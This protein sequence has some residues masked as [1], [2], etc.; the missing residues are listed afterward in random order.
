MSAFGVASPLPLLLALLAGFAL[1]AWLRR[2]SGP[3]AERITELY[4]HRLQENSQ[5]IAERDARLAVV[6]QEVQALRAEQQQ[7]R[8]SLADTEVLVTQLRHSLAQT[9]AL[10]RQL[11]EREQQLAQAHDDMDAMR[12]DYAAE[13]AELRRRLGDADALRT[14]LARYEQQ[15]RTLDARLALV[16]RDKDQAIAEFATRIAELEPLAQRAAEANAKAH[17]EAHAAATAPASTA[18]DAPAAADAAATPGSLRELER[19]LARLRQRILQLESLHVVIQD[20]DA[21]ILQ[22]KRQLT[23]L[24]P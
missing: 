12:A 16:Q 8:R 19:D 10:P 23:E 2:R 20:R 15:L 18:A 13:V 22:L 9:Q 6:T 4:E 11:L 21:Q 14:Q 3:D 24:S 7:D 5:N 17:A 1:G